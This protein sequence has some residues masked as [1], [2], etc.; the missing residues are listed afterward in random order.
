MSYEVKNHRKVSGLLL[1]TLKGL[2]PDELKPGDHFLVKTKISPVNTFSTPG[3]FNYKKYL[4]R[5]SILLKGWV[6]SPRNIIKVHTVKSPDLVPEVASL[7]YFPERI[8]HHIANFL[9]ETLTQPS[10]GLYKAILIGDRSDIAPSVLDNFTNGGCI[11]ILAI[12][13]M[14]MGILALV[15]IAVMTWLL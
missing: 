8:R 3:S 5:Q 1:L 6:D 15:T 13:G 14:H 11:H 12:S 7:L 2:I 9:D 4:A 10:R